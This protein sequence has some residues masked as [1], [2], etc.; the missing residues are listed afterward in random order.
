MNKAVPR[1]PI[2]FS[3][4]I[5][6]VF[7]VAP[8]Q[9]FAQEGG[10]V[11]QL[12]VT[13]GGIQEFFISSNRDTFDLQIF[14]LGV[15]KTPVTTIHSLKGV[16][17]PVPDS[18]YT[19]G[20]GWLRTLALTIPLD[21]IA[22]VYEADFPTST[23][24][25]RIIFVVKE[26]FLGSYSKV[27]VCLPVNTYEAY[28]NWG[29][30][31]LYGYNSTNKAAAYKVSYDRP[32]SDDTSVSYFQWNDMFVRWLAKENTPVEYCTSLDLDRDPAFLQHYSLFVSAGHDEYWSRPERNSCQ[33]FLDQGGRIMILSGNT[34][35]WQVRVED[36]GHTLVCYK[37]YHKDPL[38]KKQ[39]SIVTYYWRKYPILDSE[40]TLTGVSFEQ[41][42]YV[43][44]GATLTK[45]KGY[46][47][48]AV[49]NAQH[50]IYNNTNVKDGDIFGYKAAIVGYE[51]DG[52]WFSWKNGT[53]TVTGFGG[54]PL[55]YSILGLSAAA[56][57]D[58][59]YPG[60][61]TMGYYTNLKG[62]AVFNA[63]VT[64][65]S[66]GLYTT[67]DSVVIQV[68][69]N[70]IRRL[71]QPGSLPPEIFSYS[72][73]RVT[74][75]SINNMAVKLGHRTFPIRYDVA[76][77]FVV[78]ALDP[79]RKPLH[80]IWSI[81]DTIIGQ[82]SIVILTSDD[83][84]FF[85]KGVSLTVAVSNGTDTVSLDWALLTPGVHFVSSPSTLLFKRHSSFKYFPKAYSLDDGPL[86]YKLVNS[87]SCLH[88][89]SNT[90]VN[91][92]M[93]LKIG[94]YPVQ[95]TVAD[96]SG[97]SDIQS[98][99]LNVQDSTLSSVMSSDDLDQSIVFPNPFSNATR[100]EFDL[101]KDLPVMVEIVTT[102]GIP[103]CTMYKNDIL[104]CG[105][106]VMFWDGCDEKGK[107]M[108]AGTYLCRIVKNGKVE[109]LKII[110]I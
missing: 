22:G 31:S 83:K 104:V 54:T 7:F 48:Y 101:A 49:F 86:H 102:G 108:S 97:N 4:G 36:D 37:D 70:V 85:P 40:N 13:K 43:N 82:D 69:R 33:S 58:G 59:L 79:M 5:I 96:T 29:G 92:I 98:F 44:N 2:V 34:C 106:H 66:W 62:G 100:I 3:L 60:N 1:L 84:K 76:D 18:A 14:R 57:P 30:K 68:T 50:W 81:G 71:L 9:A 107:K 65:W 53:P 56:T 73:V 61:T 21:W 88:M 26:V 28:N 46:G 6:I 20:C 24:T 93:D 47:G 41:G 35:W 45:A 103:V 16:V 8:H 72:P 99:D 105:K 87:P 17:Q 74:S 19:I 110:K 42:G 55:N 23:G 51:T 78:H 80:Y 94:K 10:Y 77:T 109:I 64:N 38:F 67:P 11:S 90:V 15:Q 39:D 63:A 12:S 91:G 75:D 52:A 32:F 25:K 89:D 95:I 27:V